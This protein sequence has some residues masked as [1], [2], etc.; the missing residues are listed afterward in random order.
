LLADRESE[1]RPPEFARIGGIHL[2]ERLE[3]P[4]HSVLGDADSRVA[5]LESQSGRSLA[6]ADRGGR[7]RHLPDLGELDGVGEEVE[8]DLTHSTGIAVNVG[9]QVVAHQTAELEPLAVGKLGDDIQRSLHHLD[10]VAVDDLELELP[11]LD[12]REVEDVIDDREQAV[13]R[14]P[15][16]L[17]ELHLLLVELRFEKE[18]GH[19]DDSIHRRPDLVTHHGQELGLG[20]R[21]FLHAL[22]RLVQSQVS[23]LNLPEH[24]VEDLDQVSD[25][26]VALLLRPHRVVAAIRDDLCDPRQF[27][28]RPGHQAL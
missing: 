3:Q 26:V 23:A 15:Y 19:P 12:L 1:T 2:R 21:R 10:E 25:L 13:G 8:K 18:P 11:R 24:R 4:I 20:G 27:E 7:E 6:F 9:R 16:G 5:D 17:R 14:T 22:H 28:N